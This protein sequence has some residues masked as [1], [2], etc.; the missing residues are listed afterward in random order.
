MCWVVVR[1]LEFK[2]CLMLF[3]YNVIIKE[4]GMCCIV[5]V[6]KI[7]LWLIKISKYL[8]ILI[9]S[10]DDF[11]IDVCDGKECILFFDLF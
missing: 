5:Y 1:F 10:D 7:L 8:L 2:L 6:S 3:C 11:D 9:I 4:K